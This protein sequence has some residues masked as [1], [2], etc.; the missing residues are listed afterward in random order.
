MFLS[1]Y[2]SDE[3]KHGRADTDRSFVRA[4]TAERRPYLHRTWQS[5][6][7]DTERLTRRSCGLSISNATICVPCLDVE[8]GRKVRTE[9]AWRDR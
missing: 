8:G 3:T 6:S 9:V 5:M 2:R 7:G 1:A 4:G